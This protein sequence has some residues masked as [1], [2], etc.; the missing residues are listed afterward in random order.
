[1]NPPLVAAAESMQQIASNMILFHILCCLLT[2]FLW[3]DPWLH[4]SESLALS[5]GPL[6]NSIALSLAVFAAGPSSTRK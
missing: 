6:L 4:V 1:M 3:L 2:W 5:E